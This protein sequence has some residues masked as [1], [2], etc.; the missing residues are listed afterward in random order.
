[1]EANRWPVWFLAAGLLW[2]GMAAAPPLQ[3]ATPTTIAA[4]LAPTDTSTTPTLPPPWVSP[5]PDE[6]G[7][8]TIVVQPGDSMWV[9]AARAGLTLAELWALNNLTASS[10]INP[11]DVLLIGYSTPGAAVPG[12]GA[13]LSTTPS[14]TPP[15]PTLRPSAT[16]SEA[17]ICLTAFEDLD[18]DGVRDEGEPLRAGVAFTVYNTQAVVANHVTDGHSEPA[19]LRLPPG[20]YRVTR[21]V[22]SGEAL[23]TAGDWALSLSAGS[24]LHQDFGSFMGEAQA[25][26]TAGSQP[27][28]TAVQSPVPTLPGSPAPLLPRSPAS[29]SSFAVRLAGVIALFLCG[30]LLL[31]AVLILLFRGVR[32][33][34]TEAGAADTLPTKSANTEGDDTGPRG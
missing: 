17:A 22:L 15:P 5:T 12:T 20:E 16:P 14:P 7:A 4:T 19:C 18:R 27:P 33:R 29:P 13:P 30:L 28:T 10:I 26:P 11:G 31:G 24:E 23:T 9:I 6:T 1:M 3:E 2:A 32:D 8:I 25:A 21:S 34:P